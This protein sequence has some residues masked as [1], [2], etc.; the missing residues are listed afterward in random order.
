[1]E[2][3]LEID[4]NDYITLEILYLLDNYSDTKNKILR[5]GEI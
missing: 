1:M 4:I 5:K 2:K 3:R